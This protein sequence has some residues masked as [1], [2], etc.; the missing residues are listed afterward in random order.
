MFK[1]SQ[2][3]KVPP[4]SELRALLL[5]DQAL[6]LSV[7]SML[8]LPAITTQKLSTLVYSVTSGFDKESYEAL[9]LRLL[10]LKLGQFHKLQKPI[11]DIFRD[12]R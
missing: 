11:Q 8:Q 12:N 3:S 1:K 4:L 10:R 6:V 2:T 5:E 7:F 9:I